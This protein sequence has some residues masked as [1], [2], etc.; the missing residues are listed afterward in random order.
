MTYL[1]LKYYKNH[2]LQVLFYTIIMTYKYAKV[3]DACQ[4]KMA[5]F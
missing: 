2:A 4:H 1:S 5:S 3:R